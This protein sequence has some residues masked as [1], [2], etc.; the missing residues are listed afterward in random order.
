M[1][2]RMEHKSIS[3]DIT[4]CVSECKNKCMRH[5]SNYKFKEDELVCMSDFN[6]TSDNNKQNFEAIQYFRDKLTLMLDH[7]ELDIEKLETVL[8]LS[9]K[10]AIIDKYMNYLDSNYIPKWKIEYLITVIQKEYK[11]GKWNESQKEILISTEELLKSLFK[12]E[13]HDSVSD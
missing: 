10:G 1:N 4:F 2:H 5:I 12:E 3:H 7:Y 11:K 9:E 8:N 6:C 13:Q